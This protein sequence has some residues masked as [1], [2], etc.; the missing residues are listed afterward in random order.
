MPLALVICSTWNT[1]LAGDLKYQ[2]RRTAN[3]HT[4]KRVWILSQIPIPPSLNNAYPTSKHGYRYKSKALVEWERELE[5]WA[6]TKVKELHALQDLFKASQN[7]LVGIE[8]RYFF[9]KE[10]ILTKL[11]KVKKLDV[12]NRLK[13]LIDGITQIIGIDDS[14]IWEG[15]FSKHVSKTEQDYCEVKIYFLELVPLVN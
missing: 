11:G 4:L 5:R 6:F 9:R 13:C 1:A 15:K 7:A 2:L 12:D 10:K 8:C 14:Y 3:C